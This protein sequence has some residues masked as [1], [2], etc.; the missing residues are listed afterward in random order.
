MTAASGVI[1][2][3]GRSRRPG[4]VTGGQF[5]VSWWDWGS[6]TDAARRS[7]AEH[8]AVDQPGRRRHL[9]ADRRRI[10]LAGVVQDPGQEPGP[11][12]WRAPAPF[13]VQEHAPLRPGQVLLNKAA[14]LRS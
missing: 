12:P 1:P 10:L 2:A 6:A 5:K 8:P 3:A 4:R 9:G 14:I 11:F 13:G 7:G